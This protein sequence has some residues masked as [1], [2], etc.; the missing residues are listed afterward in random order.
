ME[1]QDQGDD[2][3]PP[4]Q[5][6]ANSSSRSAQPLSSGVCAVAVT[7]R[8]ILQTHPFDRGCRLSQSAPI[9]EM[10][11]KRGNCIFAFED[12]EEYYAE[13]GE[14][15]SY[16]VDDE[17]LEDDAGGAD[18]GFSCEVGKVVDVF[19]L[20]PDVMCSRVCD[21]GEGKAY[22]EP[23][24]FCCSAAIGAW[25]VFCPHGLRLCLRLRL[26]AALYGQRSGLPADEHNAFWDVL[27]L[28]T[29]WFL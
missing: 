28:L 18:V 29:T 17:A 10:A 21:S 8:I 2:R 19:E 15:E 4:A 23:V 25:I 1:Q 14:Y 3:N 9:P 11:R 16:E 12:E 13:N 26:R 20:V 22:H 7:N 5:N 6:G 27:L 24:G